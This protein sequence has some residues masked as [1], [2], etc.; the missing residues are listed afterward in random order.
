MHLGFDE[1]AAVIAAPRL[2]DGTAQSLRVI[3]SQMESSG[4]SEITENKEI[5]GSRG[6]FHCGRRPP[7]HPSSMTVHCDGPE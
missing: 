7:A 3:S 2:P 6:A 5:P 1:A 4:G